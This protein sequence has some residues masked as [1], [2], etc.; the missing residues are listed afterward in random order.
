MSEATTALTRQMLEWLAVRPRHYREVMEAWRT[1][2]PRLTIWEDAWSEGLLARDPHTGHVLL[3]E[4][5][6]ALLAR[7]T[8]HS[9][10]N[11]P[12]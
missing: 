12:A 8:A 1:N 11:G 10:S 9:R 4:K 7:P 2:C 5:G 3:S 6:R